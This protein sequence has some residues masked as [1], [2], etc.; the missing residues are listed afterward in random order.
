MFDGFDESS[1]DVAPDVA[2][3]VRHSGSGPPVVLLHGYP[4][5]GVCWHRVAP[6]LAHGHRVV[7]PDLRAM[8]ARARHPD[9]ADHTTLFKRTMANDIVALMAAR[10][11]PFRRGRA[12]SPVAV[13]RIGWPSRPSGRVERLCTLDIV[14]TIEQFELLA[15]SR[16]SAVFGFHWYFL[17]TAPLPETLISAR[18]SRISSRSWG[19]GPGGSPEPMR[20]PPRPWRPT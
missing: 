19:G 1:V 14:P 2:L 10:S 7:V 17:A 13:W 15:S 16:R 18:P 20:S 12:R 6:A 3:R 5:N 11:R 9:D 8:A 4:Q